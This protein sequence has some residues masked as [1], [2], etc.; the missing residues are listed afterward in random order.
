MV[1]VKARVVLWRL[2]QMRSGEMDRFIRLE[3]RII[4]W[5]FFQ[6]QVEV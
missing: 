6:L 5:D 3:L 2:C 1:S 4:H